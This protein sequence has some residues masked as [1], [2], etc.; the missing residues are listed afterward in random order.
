[1]EAEVDLHI[2]VH[3]TQNR[4]PIQSHR[5]TQSPQVEFLAKQSVKSQPELVQFTSEANWQVELE[6]ESGEA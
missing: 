1:M 6:K 2:E 5:L 4:H 3:H